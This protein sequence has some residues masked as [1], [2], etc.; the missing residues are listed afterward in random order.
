[1]TDDGGTRRMAVVVPEDEIPRVLLVDPAVLSD[2]YTAYGQARELSPVARLLAPGLTPIW[3]LTRYADAKS[4]LSSPQFGFT[5]ASMT[6]RPDMPDSGLEYLESMLLDPE[7]HR[8]LRR[9][10]GPA[11]TPRRA[12]QLRPQMEAIVAGLIDDMVAAAV[13]GQV[14]LLEHFARPLPIDVLCELMG[15]P[16]EDRPQWRGYGAAVSAGEGDRWQ[17]AM[18]AVLASTERAIA[19]RRAAPGDDVISDLVRIQAEDGDRLNDTEIAGLVWL[20]M[21]ASSTTA[22][23]VANA[24]L[25]LLTHPEHMAELRAHPELMPKAVEEL[26]RWCSLNIISIPRYARA[27]VELC[28]VPIR[29]GEPVVAVLL[30]ANRDPRTYPDPDRLD[31]HRPDGTPNSLTFA[32]GPHI[33]IGAAMA[34]VMVDVSLTTLLARFPD[35][36]LAV[37]APE[38]R[39]VKDPG[40]WRVEALPLRLS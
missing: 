5:R 3:A 23:F 39:R 20:I 8:R 24:L 32:H 16:D 11:F 21:V 28:G 31:F 22:D 1:M 38:V 35:L 27:D 18:P 15:I 26:L 29:A 4:M 12:A 37:P 7:V 34:R 30:A 33:C 6:I 2:P 13:D 14:D 25:A 10:V 9:M 17:E 19:R 40:T 36:A